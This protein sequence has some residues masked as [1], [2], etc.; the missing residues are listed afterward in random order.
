MEV[1]GLNQRRTRMRKDR[2]GL[3]MDGKS[4]ELKLIIHHRHGKTL[5]AFV[6]AWHGIG[7]HSLQPSKT[8][9]N[10]PTPT[11]TDQNQAS[12]CSSRS[13]RIHESGPVWY[14]ALVEGMPEQHEHTIT[15][16][17]VFVVC[18]NNKVHL[19]KSP[20]FD[21][22]DAGYLKPEEEFEASG[23]MT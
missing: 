13:A 4:S 22:N 12:Q 9:Q 1:Q 18:G 3:G 23:P 19:R 6:N 15:L 21:S 5:L 16:I 20:S 14:V 11:N 7:Q 8:K 2:M 10:Q 17:R